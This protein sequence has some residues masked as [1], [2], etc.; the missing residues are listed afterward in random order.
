MREK[1]S[2]VTY[3]AHYDDNWSNILKLCYSLRSSTDNGVDKIR[4]SCE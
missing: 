3:H 1:A 4:D 2:Y